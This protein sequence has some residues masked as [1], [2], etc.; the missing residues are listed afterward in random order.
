MNVYNIVCHNILIVS[1]KLKIYKYIFQIVENWFKSIKKILSIHISI[2]TLISSNI[3][4]FE[5]VG[6]S[7]NPQNNSSVKILFKNKQVLLF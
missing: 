2:C 1:H 6:L 3:F 7:K 5:N 4:L